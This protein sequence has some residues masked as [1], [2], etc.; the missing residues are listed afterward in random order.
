[1][2]DGVRLRLVERGRTR[3]VRW[4]EVGRLAHDDV[5][6]VLG[7]GGATGA[8]FE[9]GVLLALA[10]DHGV[11]S[12]D[13]SRL[14]GTSAGSVGAAL[15]ALGAD[16]ADIAAIVADQPHQLSDTAAGLGVRF[17][18]EVPPMPAWGIWRFPWPWSIARA[19]CHAVRGRYA[20]SF[21]QLLRTG[22]HDMQAVVEFLRGVPWPRPGDGLQVCTTDTRTGNR[23]VLDATS[24]V[25][26][27]DAVAASCAVPGLMRPVVAG[28]TTLVDGGVVS[29]TNADL[30]AGR[31]GP[32]LVIVVSPMSGPN[33]RS[34]IGRMSR[35]FAAR[36][37][38]H[39]LRRFD[40]G[41]RVLVIEPADEL[42]NVVIDDAL[43]P[44]ASME[45]LA[46]AFV[47]PAA[48]G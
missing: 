16:A 29:P 11:R 12:T 40:R 7:A 28:G 10:V 42:S 26:L 32:G 6:L 20:A 30:L 3:P 22:D 44:S 9:S 43:D 27:R 33:A 4:D 14:V 24:G 13:A 1:M 47:G 5:G 18:A 23:T 46:S 37:L 36:C 31:D 15:V 17:D 2:I 19:A 25:P 45:I 39:E 41:Q 8:A 35:R 34:A 48:A 21:V 38:E